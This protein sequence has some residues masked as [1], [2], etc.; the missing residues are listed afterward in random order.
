MWICRRLHRLQLEVEAGHF[1]RSFLF[2]SVDR[3]CTCGVRKLSARGRYD[4][5]VTSGQADTTASCSPNACLESS[6]QRI[7]CHGAYYS[8]ECKRSYA[9]SLFE[10][11]V[12]RSDR[13][14]QQEHTICSM[15]TDLTVKLYSTCKAAVG[16][17][18]SP[19]GSWYS[20][21]GMTP[22]VSCAKYRFKLKIH[23]CSTQKQQNLYGAVYGHLRHTALIYPV[24]PPT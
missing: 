14:M 23:I 17:D 2:P 20:P 11:L 7:L 22:C 1:V 21:T 13:G 19:R 10:L 24:K 8:P 18:A 5:N 15:F 6:D 9:E 4:L 12:R 3:L 16:N